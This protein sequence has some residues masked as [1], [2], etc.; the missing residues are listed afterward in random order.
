[1]AL[2]STHTNKPT[3]ARGIAYFQRKLSD[4]TYEGETALSPSAEFAYTIETETINLPSQESGVGEVIDTTDISV[5]RSVSLVCNR[6]SRDIR[7]LFFIAGNAS[8][9]QAS[10]SVTEELASG[11]ARSDQ[12]YQIGHSLNNAGA[13]NLSS[14]EIRS[15]EGDNAGA[16][17]T[18]T[19]YVVGDFVQPATP[20]DHWYMCTVAGT[21][22]G[23][24]PTWPTD[25]STVSDGTVTWQDMGLI[26]YVAD[27]DYELDA[28]LGRVYTMTSGAIATA[29][30]LGKATTKADGT[31]VNFYLEFDYTKAAKTFE[32]IA[33]SS[34]T[35]IE[36]RLR[37]EEINPKGDNN[38]HY[39]PDVRLSPNGDHALKSGNEYQTCGFTAT[40]RKPS[41]SEALY[42]NEKPVA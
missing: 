21:S 6:M 1:M 42:V 3:V 33:T 28:T 31:T 19:A 26:V 32:Q 9:T 18:T 24:A 39:A 20:N 10:G 22:G 11:V 7:A 37:F 35:S 27:T 5:A 13:R 2:G 36:G 29:V 16:A 30:A 41:G 8:V 25:G 4:G 14:V 12:Y 23:S 17:A 15:R 40:I 38:I 34:T